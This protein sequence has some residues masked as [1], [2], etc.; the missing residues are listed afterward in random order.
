MLKVCLL[1]EHFLTVH[2]VNALLCVAYAA[3]LEVV[4]GS[5]VLSGC[6][7]GIDARHCAIFEEQE[8]GSCASGCADVVGFESYD[9]AFAVVE[10]SEYYLV[11][12]IESKD[13][14]LC[15]SRNV[16]AT[17]CAGEDATKRFAACSKCDGIVARSANEDNDLRSER[18]HP[19]ELP[20][21]WA[22]RVWPDQLR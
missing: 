11:L 18:L 15:F 14:S 22:E 19:W 2:D 8:G 5:T 17:T 10:Q 7:H 4:N 9:V 1:H 13:V 20:M 3:T 16:H 12:A 21:L 6:V